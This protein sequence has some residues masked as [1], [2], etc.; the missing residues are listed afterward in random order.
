MV[1]IDIIGTHST[2]S[3]YALLDEGSTVTIINSK[4]IEKI[5]AKCVRVNVSLKGVGSEEAIAMS[6][7]KVNLRIK[8]GSSIFQIKNVLVVNDLALPV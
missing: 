2:T 6:S 7:E 8:S 4:I 3:I 5:G 1:P